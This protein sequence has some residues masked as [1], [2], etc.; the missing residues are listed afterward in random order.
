MFKKDTLPS[1]R[2]FGNEME[3]LYYIMIVIKGGCTDGI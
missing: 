3:Y 2:V 1:V